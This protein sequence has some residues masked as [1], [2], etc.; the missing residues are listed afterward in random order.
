MPNAT[1]I[2]IV[3]IG[4]A[5]A[6]L[7]NDIIRISSDNAETESVN[8]EFD[9]EIP[10][11]SMVL[12]DAWERAYAD[13]EWKKPSG[14]MPWYFAVYSKG[15]TFC[16]GVKTGANSLCSWRY[17]QGRVILH[18]DVRNGT[19]G[20]RLNG[21]I[22]DVC[23][24]VT[25]E[26]D[27][28]VYTALADFCAKLCPNPILPNRP[29][30]GGNDWYCNYGDNSLEK[31]LKHTKRIVECSPTDAP[32][33]YMVIDDGWQLCHHPSDI[34]EYFFNGGPWQYANSNFA[35]MKKTAEEIVKNG[36]IPGLWFRP[37]WTIEKVPHDW[38]LK[39]NGIKITLD[40]S[41]PGVLEKI[42]HD[43]KTFVN[44][45]YKLIKHDFST[46][47]IFGRWGFEMGDDLYQGEVEFFDK[48]KTTAE[49]INN[50][51][52][53]ISKAAEDAM[54]IGCNTLSHLSAGV[55]PLQRTGDDTSGKDWERTK[56]YGINTLAFRMCQH[57]IFYC[58]DADCV[59]IT[60]DVPWDKNKQWLDV[61]S[62]SGTA[63]FVSVAD[64]AYT[65]EVKTAVTAAFEKASQNTE[66]SKPLDWFENKLPTKWES[67]YGIDKYEW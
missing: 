5:K 35:D 36:A 50:F 47:D 3:A 45:G 33:P 8:V 1:N 30:Y 65:D 15:K 55:F 60:N 20:V 10:Q 25:E 52:L 63:L 23:C 64:D 48:T 9:F 38:V 58:A 56:N 19:G 13:M 27:C 29:V 51:Y 11:D 57:N 26:Y 62:K 2:N 18:A 59:G 34:D 61:L 40:P 24:I 49:I 16:F 21:R 46:F 54:V 12:C 28:D 44:W 42:A 22:L 37:L 67:K 32:Q 66:A 7:E 41:H 43:I 31:I 17:E 14:D 39:K 6:W 4:E 53:T